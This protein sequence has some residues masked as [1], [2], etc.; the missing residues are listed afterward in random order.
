MTAYQK[1]PRRNR[2][3]ALREGALGLVAFHGGCSRRGSAL[4]LPSI[5]EPQC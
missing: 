1:D 5:E 3:P 4:A 2:K